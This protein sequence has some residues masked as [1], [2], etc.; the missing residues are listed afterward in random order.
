MQ[1]PWNFR[2]MGIPHHPLDA[3]ERGD[4]FRRALRIAAGDQNARGGILGVRVANGVARLR[5]S[6][7]GDGAS[8]QH[9]N[10]RAVAV[11]HSREADRA[12][13]T[14]DRRCVGLRCSASEILNGKSGQG[15]FDSSD[16][17]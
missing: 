14:L 10:F 16:V 13:F 2:E 4:F 6:G 7:G 17:P 3:F 11:V 1:K 15:L 5:I 12:K 8:V 9:H